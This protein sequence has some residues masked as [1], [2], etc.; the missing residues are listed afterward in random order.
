[1]VTKPA[2]KPRHIW[3]YVMPVLFTQPGTLTRLT[4][5]MLAPIIP[6][7][8]SSHGDFLPA[9]KK[10]LLSPLDFTSLVKRTSSIM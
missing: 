10:A 3:M 5:L 4:P 6:K 7:A 1:M 8:T 9:R 2:K